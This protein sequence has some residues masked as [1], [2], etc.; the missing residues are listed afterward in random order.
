MSLIAL[1]EGLDRAGPGDAESLHWAVGRA[2]TQPGAAV[3]DAGCGLGADLAGLAQAV[4][5]ARI[6]AVDLAGPFLARVRADHPQVRV[7]E[8]D[9]ADPPGGPFDLIW[10]AGAIYNLGVTEGLRAWRR[11]LAARGRVAFT[12]MAWRVAEPSADAVAFWQ[13][14]GLRLT[15][16]AGLV[17]QVEDAGYRVLGQRWLGRAAWEAY[18]L[19]LA[20]RL[21]GDPSQD[22]ALMRA[23]AA[24]WQAHGAEFGYLLIV[25][26][27]A[28]VD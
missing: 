5:G 12:D 9:M 28:D 21:E 8:A 15:D 19:P 23:E 10:S 6:V 3:L 27:P 16:A 4:P 20:A 17:A 7:E 18:Y 26:E 14:E 24:L 2:G 11:H 22:A 1:F 13:A 25:A